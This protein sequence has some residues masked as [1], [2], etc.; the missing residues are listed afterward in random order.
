MGWLGSLEKEGRLFDPQLLLELEEA[1][2]RTRR[3]CSL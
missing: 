1:I 2:E 3:N